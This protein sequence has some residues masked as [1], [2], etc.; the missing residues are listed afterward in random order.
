MTRRN[1]SGASAIWVRIPHRQLHIY[2][3]TMRRNSSAATSRSRAHPPVICRPGKR[4]SHQKPCPFHFSLIEPVSYWRFLGTH[5]RWSSGG[6]IM[7]ACQEVP[8]TRQLQRL[9]SLC[10]HCSIIGY[11]EVKNSGWAGE[12]AFLDTDKSKRS[13]F[14]RYILIPLLVLTATTYVSVCIV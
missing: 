14:Y 10:C 2:I 6:S 12:K 11:G 3:T 5:I 9:C 4:C 13:K 1:F 8:C 7:D